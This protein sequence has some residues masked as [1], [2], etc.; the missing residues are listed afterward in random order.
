[1]QSSLLKVFFT[2][3]VFFPPPL[4]LKSNL[5]IVFNHL[6]KN[7]I[8]SIPGVVIYILKCTNTNSYLFLYYE[9]V[10]KE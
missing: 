2:Y 10:F 5:P 9:L 6:I 4:F 3:I 8:K 7:T 1:M